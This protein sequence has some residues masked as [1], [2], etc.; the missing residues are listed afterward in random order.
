MKD[1]TPESYARWIQAQRPP[2]E[3][4]LDQSETDQ[5]RMSE[6]GAIYRVDGYI[7]LAQAIADPALF[8]AQTYAESDPEAAEYLVRRLADQHAAAL[9][10]E[11][12]NGSYVTRST[13]VRSMDQAMEDCE[14]D[15]QEV[16]AA[17]VEKL[18][19]DVKK[20]RFMGMTPDAVTEA[21]N[22]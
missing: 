5:I 10:E 9:A 22:G 17:R 6:Q 8:E 11:P 14:K 4:F 20:N 18:A 7:E 21:A 12:H 16:S 13:P 19:G 3:W 1:C 2:L 15:T